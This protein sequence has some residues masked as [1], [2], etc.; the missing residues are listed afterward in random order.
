MKAKDRRREQ[1]RKA[2]SPNRWLT[3]KDLNEMRYDVA[4]AN[5][6]ARRKGQLPLEPQIVVFSCRCNCFH[7][8]VLTDRLASGGG[9]LGR[10]LNHEERCKAYAQMEKNAKLR[11]PTDSTT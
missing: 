11:R 5:S 2:D 7:T 6:V 3:Q 4:I 9:Y 1:R 10:H 8:D